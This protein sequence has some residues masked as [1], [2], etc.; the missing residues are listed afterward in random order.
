[1]GETLSVQI[2]DY[3]HQTRFKFF[4][5]DVRYCPT[6]FF[7]PTIT[8]FKNIHIYK[9]PYI[10]YNLL[11]EINTYLLLIINLLFKLKSTIFH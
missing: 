9:L 1:M 8:Y 6:Y 5:L 3:V 11:L 4:F 2:L 7:K 10:I